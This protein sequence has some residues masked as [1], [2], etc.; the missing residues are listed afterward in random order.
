MNDMEDVTDELC[1][2]KWKLSG[3]DDILILVTSSVKFAAYLKLGT[4]LLK[5]HYSLH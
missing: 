4:S 3:G 5:V 1:H 2:K